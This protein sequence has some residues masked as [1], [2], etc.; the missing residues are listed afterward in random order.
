MLY[1]LLIIGLLIAI[2]ALVISWQV[3]VRKLSD[4]GW[5]W[6][7]VPYMKYLAIETDR[8]LTRLLVACSGERWDEI[9]GEYN[10]TKTPTDPPLERVTEGLVWIGVPWKKRV[11]DWYETYADELDPNMP[12]LHSVGLE[13]KVYEYLP[14]TNASPDISEEERERISLLN[15][16]QVPTHQTADAI[17]ARATLIVS[18]IVY[19]P[20]KA[21]YNIVHRK[22]SIL[23]KVLPVWREVVGGFNYF[24]Y[25]Q[26]LETNVQ[27]VISRQIIELSREF[28]VAIGISIMEPIKGAPDKSEEE[29]FKEVRITDPKNL[30]EGKIAKDI[31]DRWGTF[32]TSGEVKDFDAADP[33]MRTKL[34]EMLSAVIDAQAA[35]QEALG[36][37]GAE[38]TKSEALKNNPE[39]QMRLVLETLKGMGEKGNLILSL[40]E[41]SGFLSSLLEKFGAFKS[42]V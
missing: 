36:I 7:R 20:M 10:K 15:A 38:I 31:Y 39:A 8:V 33:V 5:F 29:R 17:E 9:E 13:E 14:L 19:N 25:G 22:T 40:P 28:R 26:H 42:P 12:P 23:N 30:P 32:L 1:A 24:T 35:L 11:K 37:K 41:A 34:E 3:A 21:L 4:R 6:V 27:K 18:E 2:V 16:T